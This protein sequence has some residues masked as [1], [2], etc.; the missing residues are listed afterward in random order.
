MESVSVVEAKYKIFNSNHSNVEF[1]FRVV[2]NFGTRFSADQVSNAKLK[3]LYEVIFLKRRYQG[4]ILN[5]TFTKT[6][7]NRE[8][9]SRIHMSST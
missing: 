7:R 6:Q 1:R 5:L 8:I 9:N 4:S 2:Y 3:Q